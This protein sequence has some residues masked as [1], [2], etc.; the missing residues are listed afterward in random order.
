M[1]RQ[2]WKAQAPS[3]GTK[4]CVVACHWVFPPPAF[5]PTLPHTF[6]GRTGKSTGTQSWATSEAVW[7]A[8]VETPSGPRK[9]LAHLML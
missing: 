4:G 8:K 7:E 6:H 1:E 5:Y 9:T 2:V 3:W